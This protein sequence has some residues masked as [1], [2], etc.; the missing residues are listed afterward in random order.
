MLNYHLGHLEQV[1]IERGQA[2]EGEILRR[3]RAEERLAKLERWERLTP[4]LGSAFHALNNTLSG[5]VSYPALLLLKLA[6]NSPLVNP[7]LSIK[8]AGEKAVEISRD[9][10]TIVHPRQGVMVDLQAIVRQY[11]NS[12]EFQQVQKR[13]PAIALLDE[14]RDDPVPFPG[15][16]GYLAIILHHLVTNAAHTMPDGGTIRIATGRRIVPPLFQAC[17]P[18]PEGE[19]VTLEVVDQGHGLVQKDVE[20]LFTPLPTRSSNGLHGLGLSLAVIREMVKEL[21]GFIDYASDGEPGSR[22]TIFFPLAPPSG[23]G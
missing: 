1:L 13:L 19:Y 10:Q 20:R 16:A 7:L 9:L 21:D 22:I 18:I 17:E 14:G 3:Q 6:D 11:R 5:I 23:S 8:Q 4:I 12:T 15:D 2:L